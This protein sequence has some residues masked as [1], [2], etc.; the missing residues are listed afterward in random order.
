LQAS[1]Q[2]R[3]VIITGFRRCARPA[4]KGRR[5]AAAECILTMLTVVLIHMLPAHFLF[6][7]PALHRH[8]AFHAQVLSIEFIGRETP[9]ELR[10]AAKN[11]AAS[12]VTGPRAAPIVLSSEP[13]RP[14]N[15]T[16]RQA[17]AAEPTPDS[18]PSGPI[19]NPAA[20]LD[21]SLPTAHRPRPGPVPPGID[22]S[23]PPVEFQ[24]TRFNKHWVPDGGEIQQ[25]WA[26]RSRLAKVLLSATGALVKPCTD[27]ERRRREP[28]CAGAQYQGE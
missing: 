9:I 27:A 13:S 19:S 3:P 7:S 6:R 21:L 22:R 11:P 28:R 1:R 8:S 25:T 5:Q 4:A 24:E 10:L 12:S 20:Q 2:S 15:S 26:A 14:A 17:R 16:P 23:E 18:A